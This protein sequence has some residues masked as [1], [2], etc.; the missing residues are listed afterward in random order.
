MIKIYWNVSVLWKKNLLNIWYSLTKTYCIS[1]IRAFSFVVHDCGWGLV[2]QFVTEST[3]NKSHD[4]TLIKSW[5]VDRLCTCSINSRCFWKKKGNYFF[6]VFWNCNLRF[7]DVKTKKYKIISN[8]SWY[9]S[10]YNSIFC[11]K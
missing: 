9:I 8:Y 2:R 7:H 11:I 10:G 1:V 3:G 6:S 4:R 5:T